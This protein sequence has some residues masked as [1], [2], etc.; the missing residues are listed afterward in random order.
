VKNLWHAF[1]ADPASL[2]MLANERLYP[3]CGT[4]CRPTLVHEL[5]GLPRDKIRSRPM[6]LEITTIHA[7][8]IYIDFADPMSTYLTRGAALPSVPERQYYSPFL[9]VND[10]KTQLFDQLHARK[11]GAS[12]IMFNG[13]KHDDSPDYYDPLANY[14]L[15]GGVITFSPQWA[16]A[17]LA[18]TAKN[19]KFPVAEGVP[20]RWEMGLAVGGGVYQEICADQDPRKWNWADSLIVGVQILNS[21]IFET[22]VGI[23]APPCPISVQDY[24]E[25]RMPFY[26]I[27]QH[28]SINEGTTLKA[29]QTVGQ[30]DAQ[31]EISA[32]VFM[33]EDGR[34]SGCAVCQKHLCDS[35]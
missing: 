7:I 25:G 22:V 16:S 10:F 2:Q 11:R 8:S 19:Y 27:V 31:T 33:S 15:E 4:K 35:M 23:E 24:I 28:T 20:G 6:V 30:I 34:A 26:H 18:D 3:R 13:I 1:P 5:Y 9:D 21:V 32:S 29:L 17:K 12:Y 14:D